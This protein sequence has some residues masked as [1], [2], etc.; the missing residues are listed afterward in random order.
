MAETRSEG[1]AAIFESLRQ[2]ASRPFKAKR[3]VGFSPA[4]ADG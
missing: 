3:R 4:G 1:A 2:L